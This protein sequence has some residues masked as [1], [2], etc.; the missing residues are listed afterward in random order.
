MSHVVSLAEKKKKK[1]S[2]VQKCQTVFKRKTKV[3]K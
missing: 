2:L 1:K 3:N